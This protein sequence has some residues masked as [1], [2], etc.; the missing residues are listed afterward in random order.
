MLEASNKQRTSRNRQGGGRQEMPQPVP[1]WHTTD[2]SNTTRGSGG[3]EPP[4]AEGQGVSDED[5]SGKKC[6]Q[7]SC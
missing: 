4:E 7:L 6:L 5:G 2:R 1:P 3:I